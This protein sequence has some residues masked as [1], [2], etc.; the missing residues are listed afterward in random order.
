MGLFFSTVLSAQSLQGYIYDKDNEGV[1]PGVNV[2]YSLQSGEKIG[3]ISDLNGFY[4][5]DLP[6]KGVDVIFSTLGFENKILHLVLSPNESKK[7]DI[8]LKTSST[9]LSEVV[10]SAGRFEQKLSEITVSMDVLKAE[11]LSRQSPVDLASTLNT[12]P[13]VD[14]NDKQPS[15]R[16]GNGWTYGVGSRCLFLVDGMNVL[17]PGNGTV[18][19]NVLPIENIEQIEV[20]KGAS[21][22]LYGSSALNGIINIRSKRPD[23]KP[24]TTL[25]TYAGIYDNPAKDSYRWSDRSF[26]KQGKYPVEPLLRSNI[27]TGVRTPIYDGLDLAHS[28]RIGN[29]DVSGSMNLFKDE[30]YREQGYNQRFRIGGNL[31][32]HQPGLTDK[33]M[34]YGFNI[35]YLSDRTADF[36]I[37]RNPSEVYR[38]SAFANMGHEGNSFDIDPFFNF[39]NTKNN[40]SHKIKA[41]F[42]YKDDSLVKPSA[43]RNKDEIL[44]SMGADLDGLN[45][46]MTNLQNG[47]YSSLVPILLPILKKDYTGAVD[48]AL[49][50]LSNYFPTATTSDWCDL[51]GSVMATGKAPGDLVR[52]YTY[53]IDYQFNKKWNS[54]ACLTTGATY[55]HTRLASEVTGIHNSDNAAL[56]IQ[57]DQ[58]FLDKISV[59]AGMRMEYYRVDKFL[60]E[61][62]TNIFG[63][64]IPFRPI[65]RA[66]LNYQVGPYSFLRASFGQGYRYP[67]LVEKYARKDIGGVGVYPNNEL[68]PEKGIN[69]EIGFK[70]GLKAGKWTGMIDLAAF[71][72]EYSDMIEFRFGFFNNTSFE[73]INSLNEV[74][75]MITKGQTPGLGAQFYNVSKARIYG[76]EIN[77]NG[78]VDFNPHTSLT[79]NLG[80]VFIEP[81]EINWKEKN[82]KEDQYTDPLQMKEKSNKS[83]YLKYRQ[84]HTAKTIVDF[85]WKRFNIGF[86][87]MVKSKTLAVDYIMVDERQKEEPELMD[88]VRTLLFG[89]SDGQTLAS[90]W[91]NINKPYCTLDLRAGVDISNSV[92]AEFKVN[93]L[94]NK[95]YSTRPMATA[96]PR[97]YIM[98]LNFRF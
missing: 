13:G 40:T 22:V 71:Y 79:Y 65:F 53:Y 17:D 60:K 70:Q 37:W 10:V 69:A 87:L 9:L 32:Y 2:Y 74:V 7:A 38:P 36:F 16:G 51:L 68:L 31:T 84:R 64:K 45:G 91:K 82:E 62:Q 66:G 88:Y 81:E 26:W 49:G 42:F 34:N 94:L 43:S 50:L 25:R 57:Y 11:Q 14:I 18:N 33:I 35:N 80:Y 55:E 5:I 23:L 54:G 8:Y 29:F 48:A 1:L 75:S 41:R 86:N 78:K 63:M 58:R 56:F 73:Y 24:K 4:K 97:T 59:S 44:T 46:F 15:I 83:K 67:S 6:A 52:N 12:L 93:N 95:E 61:A 3:V 90:Y 96:A 27:L 89:E 20:I 19:W 77:T 92:S 39:T 76:A 47:D 85:N 21:S 98:Q 28:R 30:G 72:T